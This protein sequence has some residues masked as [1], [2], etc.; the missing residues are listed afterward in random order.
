ME[1]GP[2]WRTGSIRLT[3]GQLCDRCRRV[4]PWWAVPPLSRCIRK[5]AVQ[6][7]G[8]KP[9]ISVPPWLLL[10]LLAEFM[11]DFPIVM[12]CEL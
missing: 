8:S 10:Q 2:H 1:E 7:T 9:I 4:S 11:P 6:A 5:V 3:D 12:A